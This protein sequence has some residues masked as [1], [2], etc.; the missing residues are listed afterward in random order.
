M[1][2]AKVRLTGSM[3]FYGLVAKDDLLST[4]LRCRGLLASSLRLAVSN[5]EIPV[6]KRE[7]TDRNH[8]LYPRPAKATTAPAQATP[9]DRALLALAGGISLSA[10]LA[11]MP[12]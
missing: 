2:K 3:V 6:V 9:H 5:I 8:P 4:T 11:D 12:T 10:S 7:I 1:R